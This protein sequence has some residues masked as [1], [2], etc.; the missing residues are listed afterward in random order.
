MSTTVPAVRN[1]TKTAETIR[2]LSKHLY[3][4]TPNMPV[5]WTSDDESVTTP[6]KGEHTNRDKDTPLA[7]KKMR[8]ML[9]GRFK[10]EG[11]ERDE[12]RVLTRRSLR[13]C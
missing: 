4:L 9:S 1:A 2:L 12:I 3:A 8:K 11:W 13:I 5:T 10:Y 6:W 7:M